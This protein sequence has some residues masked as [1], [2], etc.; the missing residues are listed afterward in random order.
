MRIII[1]KTKDTLTP[2]LRRR[3]RKLQDPKPSLKA[4]GT[5]IVSLAM[6]AFTDAS[7]RPSAW[8]PLSQ[9]TL[10][11]RKADGRGSKPL[12]R[13]GVLSR[14]P[15]ITRLTKSSVHTGSD[16]RYAVHHQF[17]TSTIPARPF[18]PFDEHGRPTAKAR[19]LM[20]SAAR[21]TLGL[22]PKA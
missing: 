17:G 14:S 12:M 8:A 13:T 15:R 3:L 4:M 7:L 21:K 6:R 16:R 11:R 1:K 22:S 20:M 9:R 2:D 5:V 18:F 19:T 10:Q